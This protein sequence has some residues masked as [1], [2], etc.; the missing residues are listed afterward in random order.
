MGDARALERPRITSIAFRKYKA[1][2]DFSISLQEFNV[3]V[4]PNN[5]GKSTIIGALRILGE[6]I[7]RARARSP[8][9]L[10]VRG[11]STWGHRIDLKGLPIAAENVFFNYDDSEPAEVRF[12]ISTE[13][14]SSFFSPSNDLATCFFRHRSP[15]GHRRISGGSSMS[16]SRSYQS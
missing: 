11:R 3:L 15:Y 12:R 16:K 4:G 10:E 13:T 5:S 8:D 6:G 9:P 2:E 7:R 1:L 14:S